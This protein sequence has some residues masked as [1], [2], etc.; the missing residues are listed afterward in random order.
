MLEIDLRT[1]AQVPI[2]LHYMTQKPTS[3]T[4]YYSR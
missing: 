2:S 4:L 3:I 1:R